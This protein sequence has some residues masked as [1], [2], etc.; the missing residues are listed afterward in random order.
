MFLRRAGLE[1]AAP[2]LG[3]PRAQKQEV[4]EVFAVFVAA[5]VGEMPR[6]R[7]T[8]MVPVVEMI[9]G[10]YQWAGFGLFAVQVRRRATR[11]PFLY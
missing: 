6:P 5:P 3:T 2:G 1:A 8:A 9:L 10:G 4:I 11:S 7:P